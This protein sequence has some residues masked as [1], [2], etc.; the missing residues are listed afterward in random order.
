MSR[1]S[2]FILALALLTAGC[3]KKSQ[4]AV[5]ISKDYIP[6]HVEGTEYQERQ[7]DKEQWWVMIEMTNGRKADAPVDAE[8]WKALKVGERVRADYSEG[9]HTGTIWG[10]ELHK[11]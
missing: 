8:L 1:S 10:I 11:H 4:S 2:H 6:A 9:N 3:T 7:T 5:V